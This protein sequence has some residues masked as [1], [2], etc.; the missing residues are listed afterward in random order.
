VK[1][2]LA[3]TFAFLSLCASAQVRLPRSAEGNALQQLA[4]ITG[5]EAG[6]DFG[7]FVAVSGNTLAVGAPAAS[8]VCENCGAVYV[9]TA[10]SG[11]WTTSFRSRS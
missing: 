3:F 4:E 10:V 1:T 7:L 2:A 6:D 11:D 5:T 8:D 9:Y